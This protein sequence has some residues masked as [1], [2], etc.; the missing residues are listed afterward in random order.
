MSRIGAYVA[1]FALIITACGGI[2]VSGR[3]SGIK[4]QQ[5]AYAVA[6]AVENKR[7]RE[8]EQVLIGKVVEVE[9]DAI[10]ET[11][12]LN[13]RLAATDDVVAKLRTA[14]RSANARADA[15]TPGDTDADSARSLLADCTGAYRDMA[16]TA[17]ELRANV[18][19]L[20]AYIDNVIE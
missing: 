1:V 4:H 18:L 13:R 15:S 8:A 2:F 5:D 10:E 17:D 6:L 16:R 3:Q 14:V 20:Q 12:E 19:G 9:Q 7:N 11:L